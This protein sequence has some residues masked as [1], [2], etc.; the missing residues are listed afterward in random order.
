MIFFKIKKYF[1][2]QPNYIQA[3]RTALLAEQEYMDGINIKKSEGMPFYFSFFSWNDTCNW[4][5]QL[6]DMKAPC[7][8]KEI[9]ANLYCSSFWGQKVNFFFDFS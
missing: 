3:T 7:D 4:S 5:H 8:D 6:N 1:K 2:Y 9:T